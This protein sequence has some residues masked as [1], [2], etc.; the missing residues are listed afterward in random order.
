MSDAT[1]F[2]V[3]CFIAVT[4]ACIAIVVAYVMVE[5]LKKDRCWRLHQPRE[6]NDK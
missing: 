1:V 6:W 3:L 5:Q 2:F 4:I